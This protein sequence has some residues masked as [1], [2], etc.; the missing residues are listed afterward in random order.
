M[1]RQLVFGTYNLEHGGYDGGSRERLERQLLMMAAVGA[2]AWALQECSHWTKHD[3]D[4]VEDVLDMTGAIAES[5]R[6]PGGNTGIFVR[7]CDEIT[8]HRTAHEEGVPYWHAV[9][10][11]HAAVD[12]FGPVRFASAHLAPSAPTLRLIEAEAFQLIAEKP[13]PLI[14][15]GD[16]NAF[17][18]DAADTGTEGVR[19]GQARRKRDTRAA[20]ALEE[21]MTDVGR[22]LGDRTPTV[23]HR[24]NAQLAYR[25]DRVYSTLPPTAF[26]SSRVLPAGGEPDSDHLPVVSVFTLGAFPAAAQPGGPPSGEKRGQGAQ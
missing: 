15:G 25:C 12:G 3:L 21:F 6:S 7:D 20:E 17:P 2:D 13:A 10:Q 1:T 8:V 22:A 23:G 24:R 16:W 19:P 14:A 11:V 4:L 26:T 18:L 9:A 5:N